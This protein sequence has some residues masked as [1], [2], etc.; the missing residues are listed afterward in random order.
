M[1]GCQ[2]QEQSYKSI[3]IEHLRHSESTHGFLV[4]VMA[5][6]RQGRGKERRH[7]GYPRSSCL[8]LRHTVKCQSVT[9]TVCHDT[10][11]YAFS[12]KACAAWLTGLTITLTIS[13]SFCLASLLLLFQICLSLSLS[14]LGTNHR[15]FLT[16]NNASTQP[17]NTS[18][19][20]LSLFPR[21][22]EACEYFTCSLLCLR[23]YCCKGS[24]KQVWRQ[25]LGM[26]LLCCLVSRLLT[27]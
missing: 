13:L 15:G 1:E 20:G 11:L 21:A 4:R 17:T 22:A 14:V 9:N 12:S 26:H 3:Q 27:C 25:K 24:R 19:V 10:E 16:N 2:Y 18:L 7:S 6:V 23:T 8:C 5:A